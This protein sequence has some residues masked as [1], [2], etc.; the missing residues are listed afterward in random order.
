MTI[1]EKLSKIA[2]NEEKVFK[3]GKKSQYDEFWDNFQVNGT[4]T[5]YN[6]A[7]YSEFWRNVFN[8]KYDIV[9]TDMTYMFGFFNQKRTKLN[10][11]EILKKNNVVL[12]FSKMTGWP[13]F[14][15]YAA[16]ISHLPKLDC[17]GLSG[18]A[19]WFGESGIENIEKL[20]V[21]ENASF[22]NTFYK[23]YY[24]KH[25][26]MEGCINYDIDFHYSGSLDK[27]SIESII[28]ILSETVEGRTITFSKNAINKAFKIDIDD[29]ETY[30]EGS[31]YCEL[32]NSKANWTFSYS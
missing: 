31:E 15:F 11:A 23:C 16:A 4:R 5:N 24:L 26:I 32:R 17:S 30:P 2:E 10:V 21:S 13:T 8:P 22:N 25:I 7:F 29:E 20:I 19:Y 28:S 18:L 3:A 27:E 1:S 6:H 9:P 12:D 14:V